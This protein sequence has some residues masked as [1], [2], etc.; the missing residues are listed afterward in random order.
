MKCIKSGL[1]SNRHTMS[2]DLNQEPEQ[3][4]ENVDFSDA[5]VNYEDDPAVQEVMLQG[6]PEQPIRS[7]EQDFAQLE[8]QAAEV[9]ATENNDQPFIADENKKSGDSIWKK[10]RGLLMRD[11]DSI[12]ERIRQ[13]DSAIENA[14]DTPA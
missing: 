3:N 4:P 11:P 1:G 14:G 7:T 13:L 9:Y 2:D 6:F 8:D 10:F 5:A 12:A